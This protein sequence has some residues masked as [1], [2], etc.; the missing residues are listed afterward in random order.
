MFTAGVVFIVLAGIQAFVIAL[1]GL[2]LWMGKILTSDRIAST[3]TPEEREEIAAKI[4][5]IESYPVGTAMVCA[6]TCLVIAVV[7]F[8]FQ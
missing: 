7:F 2:C 5:Q 1:R 6:V 4:A 3:S 8:Y